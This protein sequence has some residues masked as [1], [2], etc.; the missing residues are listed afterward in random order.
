MV[1]GLNGAY[2]RAQTLSLHLGTD[3]DRREG[4][5]E[6]HHTALRKTSGAVNHRIADSSHDG[7]GVSATE[8]LQASMARQVLR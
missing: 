8:I 1:T 2:R 6:D 4:S 5:T 7:T 3:G